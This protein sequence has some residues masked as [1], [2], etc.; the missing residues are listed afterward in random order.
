MTQAGAIRRR[1]RRKHSVATRLWHWAMAAAIVI[2]LA[3]G[4]AIFNAHP[5]LYWGSVGTSAEPAWLEIGARE[6]A[7]YLKIGE[8]SFDTTGV[9]GLWHTSSGHRQYTAFPGAVTLPGPYALAD[10][11]RWHIMASWILILGWPVFIAVS[12]LNGHLVRDLMPRL[13]ELSPRR[14]WRTCRDH[15]RLRPHD[16]ARHGI[17]NVLQKLTYS[18]VL[19]VLLPLVVLSG[20]AMSPA[21]AAAWPWLLDMFGGR[22]SARTFHFIFASL[23][24]LFL[25]I[26]LIMLLLY[27]PWR[28]M[29]DMILGGRREEEDPG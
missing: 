19:G 6:D 23:F 28:L 11:R 8:Q 2:L 9:L 12:L 15:M 1:A 20:L 21:I 29:K 5:R 7:G 27:N 16:K 3:S 18:G 24:S 4:L 22:Q 13:W 17:Y 26:H 14:L 10:A 25:V